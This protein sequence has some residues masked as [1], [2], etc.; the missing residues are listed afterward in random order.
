MPLI[1]LRGAIAS[2]HASSLAGDAFALR[3]VGSETD[4]VTYAPHL[5]GIDIAFY[6]HRSRYHTHLDSFPTTAGGPGAL[7]ALRNFV[8]DAGLALLNRVDEPQQKQ[9]KQ[10][11]VYFDR[12]FS[13]IA[14]WAHH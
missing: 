9:Q 14:T 6:R 13:P 11:A 3:L 8:R 12:K 4:F 1:P 10:Q 2:P 5:A 7:L